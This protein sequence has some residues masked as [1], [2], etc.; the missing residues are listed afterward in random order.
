MKGIKLIFLISLMLNFN[1]MADITMPVLFGDHMVLQRGKEIPVWG[2]AAAGEKVTV[3]LHNNVVTI[4]ADKQGKWL[5]RLPAMP[6]GGPFTLK[7]QG[8]NLFVYENVLLGDVW[9]C[10]GQS[11]MQWTVA[12][13][14][15]E[16][17][18][19]TFIDRAPLRFFTVQFDMDY[20]PKKD[21]KG[22][23]W[24]TFSKQAVNNFSAVAYHF[25]KFLNRSLEVPIGLISSNLG[26][27]SV[28]TW[29]SNEAL[30][31]FPQFE[32]EIDPIIKRGKSFEEI[33]ADFEKNKP[34]WFEKYYYKGTGIE[35]EW[36]QPETDVSE[37]KSMKLPNTW[38]HTNLKD[39]DGA[40][41]FSTSFDLPEDFDK[42][43]FTINLNQIDDFDIAWINGHKIGATYGRHNHRNYTVPADLLKTKGNILVVRVFDTGGI[44]GFTTNAF[45]GNPVLWGNWK[46]KK[47]LAINAQ[48]FPKIDVVNASPFSSPGVLFNANIAP[49]MPYAIKGAIW[50]QGESNADRAYEY[51]QLFPAMIRSWWEKW[52]QGNFPF[53]FVQLANYMT[54]SEVPEDS[55]WAELREAQ[56]M[57]L[58]LPNTGMAVA[59]DIGE[60]DN[61]HPKN[62]EEVGKRLGKSALKVAYDRGIISSGPTF[63]SLTIDGQKAIISF[64]FIEKGIIS[65][66]KYGY[67]RGFAIAGE[68]KRFY[69]AKATIKGDQVIVYSDKVA[70][71]VAVR[72]AWSNN[73]G[74]LDLY[75][76]EGLP[77]V[78]F[79]T[80]DWKGKTEGKKYTGKPR[81]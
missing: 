69:W 37:W 43:Q 4:K 62:K 38:E 2:W 49:L 80:D 72:Y 17:K 76:E 67:V 36:F 73:P 45:W 16:E 26:A 10:G 77:A 6:A 52:E 19:S 64:S 29:M 31:Q 13:T 28:E 78:P 57:A 32:S 8:N 47:G 55:E 46:Y 40:V 33:K 51:R 18:D 25:G 66:N 56:A 48:K 7:V 68:D 20:M 54:E 81:F 35:E 27:T 14:N 42:E 3:S 39:H 58:E 41:W 60:A 24:K 23:E 61:I 63:K 15:Y 75:N 70:A 50:Y 9:V 34:Q 44:G 65:K 53:L 21:L 79:R 71:P 22:G 12:Q 59:I 1:A 5:V 74:P 30:M 11:N